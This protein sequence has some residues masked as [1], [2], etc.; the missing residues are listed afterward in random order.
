MFLEQEL[1]HT[2][3]DVGVLIFVSEAERYVEIITD[4]G[5]AA[6]VADERWEE[7]VAAFVVDVSA[8]RV[9]DG[10]L[11]AIADCGKVL[12]EA[13]PKTPENRNELDDRLVLIGYEA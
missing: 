13:V 4:R 7:I 11:R 2:A 5:I 9:V 10:F 1:H 8:G 12:A 3:G 6:H